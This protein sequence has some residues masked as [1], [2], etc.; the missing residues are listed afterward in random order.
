MQYES[1]EQQFSDWLSENLESYASDNIDVVAYSGFLSDTF[2]CGEWGDHSL[3]LQEQ[4]KALISQWRDM[5][6]KW[7][8]KQLELRLPNLDY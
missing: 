7:Q 3:T 1:I 6:K 2:D 5:I 4:D 8:D